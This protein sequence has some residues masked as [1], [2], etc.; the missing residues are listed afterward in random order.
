MQFSSYYLFLYIVKFYRYGVSP[1]D[2][3]NVWLFAPNLSILLLF[4]SIIYLEF[5]LTYG[6]T[7]GLLFLWNIYSFFLLSIFFFSL[8]IGENIAETEFIDVFEVSLS[9]FVRITFLLS[10]IYFC[11]TFLPRNANLEICYWFKVFSVI[12]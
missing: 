7:R 2:W 8:I 11:S 4:K 10:L 1:A 6:R 3:L 9:V 12:F 5:W